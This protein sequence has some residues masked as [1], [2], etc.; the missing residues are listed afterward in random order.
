MTPEH[1]IAVIGK[2]KEFGGSFV[3][4][5]AVA[6]EYADPIN[7]KKIREAWPEYWKNYEILVLQDNVR[8]LP[9]GR[10]GDWHAL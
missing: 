9:G 4:A 10:G 5:L 2:M 7:R 8:P 1:E 6:Y 3:K